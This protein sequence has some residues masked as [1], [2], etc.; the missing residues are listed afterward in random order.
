[1]ADVIPLFRVKPIAFAVV[2]AR[3]G[4]V[5]KWPR[6]AAELKLAS[7]R[8]RLAS[9]GDPLAG[10]TDGKFAPRAR[11]GGKLRLFR[12]FKLLGTLKADSAAPANYRDVVERLRAQRWLRRL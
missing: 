4:P 5:E 2:P 8:W 11:R 6:K 9:A 3:L 7:P 12:V 1:V 10:L